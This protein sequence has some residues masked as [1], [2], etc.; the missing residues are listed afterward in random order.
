MHQE[1]MEI[2][3]RYDGSALSSSPPPRLDGSAMSFSPLPQFHLS[4]H[5]DAWNPHTPRPFMQPWPIP[6]HV[7]TGS[8]VFGNT[9]DHQWVDLPNPPMAGG[10][11]G[12][13]DHSHGLIESPHAGLVPVGDWTRFSPPLRGFPAWDSFGLQ[14]PEL[15]QQAHTV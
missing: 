7:Q 2:S 15:V 14:T 6:E 10:A 1:G 13:F 5:P 9:P 4:N 12:R 3:N 11:N 8:S